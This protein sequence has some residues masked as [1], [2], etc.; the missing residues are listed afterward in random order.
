MESWEVLRR[1]LET[2]AAELLRTMPRRDGDDDGTISIGVRT[3]KD[4]PVLPGAVAL[5]LPKAERTTES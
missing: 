5:D 2:L 3:R 4:P 1:R